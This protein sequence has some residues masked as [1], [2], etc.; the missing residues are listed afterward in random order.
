ML[1][2]FAYVRANPFAAVLAS[3][4]ALGQVGTSDILIATYA[5]RIFIIGRESA[6]S[7]G[8]M[9]AAAGVGAVLGPVLGR[10]LYDESPT[11]LRRRIREGFWIMPLGWAVMAWA[12]N[13]W[14]AMLGLLLNLMGGSANWTFSNVLIQTQVPDRFLGRVFALDFAFLTLASA[15]SLWL[16]GWLLD[17]LQ[18]DPRALVYLIAA[19]SVVPALIWTRYQG[20]RGA[21]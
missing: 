4:K 8:L 2:G 11:G 19:A 6:G 16:S 12:P 9:Y 21:D 10:Y 7:L 17:T 20:G 18:L 13:I 1:D 3:V 15:G 14:M 5:S